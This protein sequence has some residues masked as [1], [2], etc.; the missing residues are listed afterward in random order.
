MKAADAG[1]TFSLNNRMEEMKERIEEMNASD[2]DDDDND[3]DDDDEAS[4]AQSTISNRMKSIKEKLEN[5]RNKSDDD[6]DVDGIQ[7]P[8]LTRLELLSQ[9]VR[10][11][12]ERLGDLKETFHDLTAAN[13][14]KHEDED[15]DKDYDSLGSRD[16]DTDEDDEAYGGD[17]S[18]RLRLMHRLQS[19]RRTLNSDV[20]DDGNETS[21]AM[22]LYDDD[23]NDDKDTCPVFPVKIKK[24]VIT[25]STGNGCEIVIKLSGHST[26]NVI[27][28]KRN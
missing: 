24:N 4:D 2:D 13:G 10:E 21:P 1:E 27:V 9:K 7:T 3:D 8:Q 6:A 19:Q 16:Y 25:V 11:S 20:D 14:D 22:T 23:E 5:L 26:G 17:D 18:I 28:R 15:D 12:Q